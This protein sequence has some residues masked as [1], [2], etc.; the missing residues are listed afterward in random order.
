M[1]WTSAPVAGVVCSVCSVCS[2]CLTVAG[3][4]QERLDHE[5]L[6]KIREEGVNRS[7]VMELVSYMTDVYGPRLAASPTYMQAARWAQRTFE[8]FGLENVAL[9]PWGEYGL[10]W[11]N[12]YTSIH[13]LTPQYQ[14]IIGY[15]RTG[16]HGTNGKVI[17]D[18]VYIDPQQIHSDADLDRYRGRLRGKIVFTSPKRALTPNFSSDATRLTAADLD[19]LAAAPITTASPPA[20][21]LPGISAYQTILGV[22]SD[23]DLQDFFVDEGV[24]SLVYPSWRGDMGT[25][26]V[27]VQQ[28]R[29]ISSVDE[30]RP[31]TRRR[32][33][34]LPWRSVPSVVIAA[35]HY[36]RMMR[37]IEKG[38]EVTMEVDV[39]TEFYDDDLMDY[40]VVA[41]LAGSDLAHEVVMLGAHFDARSAGTGGT[42]AASGSA[43]VM[44]AMRILR[45]IGVRP[46]RTIRAVLWGSEEPALLGSRGYVRKHFGNPET[47]EYLP[48]HETLAGYFNLDE[49]GGRIRGIFLQSNEHTRPIFEAW[50]QPFHDQGMSTISGARTGGTDHITFNA[51]GLPGF[52]FIQDDLELSTRTLHSNMDVYDR[53]VPEDLMFNSV[54]MASFV[55]NAASRDERLPRP[56]PFYPEIFRERPFDRMDEILDKSRSGAAR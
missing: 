16:S 20:G 49:G 46:R 12:K 33:G 48:E 53:L 1:A 55:Y 43:V 47:L 22:R 23:K 50:M 51:V 7:Q 52:Q 45:A 6:A 10:G 40:N 9:E 35:E 42:D 11:E 18:V 39:R 15:P 13:M 17:S 32:D 8:A 5:V 26:Y 56:E 34:V 41:E 21:E 54:I 4:A 19:G 24:A 29:A 14:P 27:Y 31:Q 28:D 25:V 3:S 44:E 30:P 2:V 37:I 36:N 38:I